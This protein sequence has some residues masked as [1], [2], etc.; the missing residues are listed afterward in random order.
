M[1]P[2][3][4]DTVMRQVMQSHATQ[5]KEERERYDGT[6]SVHANYRSIKNYKL[7]VEGQ[8]IWHFLTL[9][10]SVSQISSMLFAFL[11]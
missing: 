6:C 11:M 7:L 10:D 2:D 1:Q 5:R 3:S 8:G 4:R 9:R